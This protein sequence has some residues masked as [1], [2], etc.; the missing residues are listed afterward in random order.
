MSNINN[1]FFYNNT[2]TVTGVKVEHTFSFFVE[3]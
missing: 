1:D 2:A 3:H